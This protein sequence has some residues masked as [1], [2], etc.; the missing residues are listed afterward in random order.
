MRCAGLSERNGIK[1]SP[2]A[3]LFRSRPGSSICYA[4]GSSCVFGAIT[5]KCG[6]KVYHATMNSKELIRRLEQAGWRLSRVKGSHHV[7]VHPIKDGHLSVPHPRKDLGIGLVQTL[8]Q[9]AGLK[10]TPSI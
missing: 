2:K 9:R 3:S 8:L 5:W 10:G 6:M 4:H 7:Y 1:L